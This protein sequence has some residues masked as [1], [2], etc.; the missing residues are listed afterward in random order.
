MSKFSQIQHKITEIISSSRAISAAKNKNVNSIDFSIQNGIL[1][2]STTWKFID[3]VMNQD[4]FV[5][6]RTEF[7]NS[8]D[9]PDMLPHVL[10]LKIGVPVILLQ[11]N[12]PPRLCNGTIIEAT[13]LN[14]K[15]KCEDVLLP[16]IPMILTDAI[17]IFDSNICSFRWDS[18]LQ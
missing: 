7:L 17:R 5:N 6:Y 10:I 9:L 4:K 1:G 14:G 2:D 13:I 3:N 11:N 15:F 8:F 16:R 18:P 12:Y